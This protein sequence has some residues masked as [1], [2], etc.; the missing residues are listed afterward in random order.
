MRIGLNLLHVIPHKLGGIE[1]YIYNLLY[2]FSLH[3]HEDYEIIIFT[4]KKYGNVFDQY[5]DKFKLIEININVDNTVLRIIYEQLFLWLK[6]KK[7]KIDLL[8]SSGYTSPLIVNCPTVQTIHDLNYISIPKIIRH[9]SYGKWRWLLVRLL[10]PLSMRRSSTIIT[11]SNKVAQDIRNTIGSKKEVWVI[12]NSLSV[13]FIRKLKNKKKK[14]SREYLLY[15]AAYYPHKN[16]INLLK[17]Y[18][19]LKLKMK[20]I[21]KLVLAGLKFKNE[22][23]KNELIQA[24]T[25]LHLEENIVLIDKFLTTEELIELYL[26]AS[27]LV[28]PSV[29]EGF[30]I[31]II[32]AMACGVAVLCSDYQALKEVASDAAIFFNPLSPEDLAAKLE[33]LLTDKKVVSILSA[34]GIQRANMKQFQIEYMGNETLRCYQETLH[35][36]N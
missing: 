6:T 30:G 8:H 12:Y 27:I 34:K 29:F 25:S 32:E 35:R 1:T 5:R 16:H 13:E 11:V 4:S 23:K 7:Y 2:S 10:S 26:N 17:G 14:G 20:E 28:F 19:I 18:S 21:P 3:N 33:Y 24:I 22:D 15:V 9:S 31:P 36:S